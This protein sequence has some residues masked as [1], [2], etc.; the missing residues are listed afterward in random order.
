MKNKKEIIS[1]SGGTAAADKGAK[2]PLIDQCERYYDVEEHIKISK[3]L[4]HWI[5][6]TPQDN[7]SCKFF[8][9]IYNE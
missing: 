9:K 8:T 1:C 4:M 2:C 3:H 6:F 5:N 7:S